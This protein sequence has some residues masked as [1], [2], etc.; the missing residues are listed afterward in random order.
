MQPSARIQILLGI[1]LVG[2]GLMILRDFST[3]T[4]IIYIFVVFLILVVW[5]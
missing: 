3:A 5:S 2:T 1:L 4:A